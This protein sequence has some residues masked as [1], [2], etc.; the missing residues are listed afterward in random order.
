VRKEGENVV[1]EPIEKAKWPDGFWDI[2]KPDPGF[3]TPDPMPPKEFS[4]DTE[5]AKRSH[6][7]RPGVTSLSDGPSKVY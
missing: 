6:G 1:L 7:F 3:E 2:F 4:F 5:R